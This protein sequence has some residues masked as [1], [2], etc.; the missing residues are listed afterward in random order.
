MEGVGLVKPKSR[1][2]KI[3]SQHRTVPGSD[4]GGTHQQLVLLASC[5]TELGSYPYQLQWLATRYILILVVL[6]LL[7]VQC[8]S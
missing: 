5:S 1:L 4:I 3:G 7:Q 2:M 6:E 8:T